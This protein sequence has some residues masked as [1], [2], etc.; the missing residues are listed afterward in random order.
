ME[1]EKGQFNCC[2]KGNRQKNS[3]HANQKAEFGG[4]NHTRNA[5]GNR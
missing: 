5:K 1:R 2:W 3:T 4:E